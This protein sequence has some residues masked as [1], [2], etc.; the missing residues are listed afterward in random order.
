M[1]TTNVFSFKCTLPT[2]YQNTKEDHII[3][4]IFQQNKSVNKTIKEYYERL[5]SFIAQK[6]LFVWKWVAQSRYDSRKGRFKT[7]G[8]VI[9]PLAVGQPLTIGYLSDLY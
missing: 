5:M 8:C 4:L 3:L 1:Y 6:K 2:K 9:I 7:R